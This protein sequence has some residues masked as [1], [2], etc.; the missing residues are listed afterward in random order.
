ILLVGATEEAGARLRVEQRRGEIR[1]SFDKAAGFV[2]RAI[3]GGLDLGVPE[4][5]VLHQAEQLAE[6]DPSAALE[7]L[8]PLVQAAQRFDL[9]RTTAH[10][11]VPASSTEKAAQAALELAELDAESA[12][13]PAPTLGE[14][15]AGAMLGLAVGDALGGPVEF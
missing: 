11:E 13:A 15:Y 9:R 7:K 12:Q 4:Q 6:R 2:R 8:R 10:T 5:R 3:E 14:R 1:A